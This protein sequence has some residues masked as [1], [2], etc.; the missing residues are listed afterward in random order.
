MKKFLSL[1]L[2]VVLSFGLFACGSSKSDDNTHKATLD[3]EQELVNICCNYS[4][5]STLSAFDVGSQNK[6]PIENGYKVTASGSYYPQDKYG[7]LGDKMLFDI[8][9]E[10]TL[11]ESGTYYR[12]NVISKNIREKTY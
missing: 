4:N 3:I 11:N 10:A 2:V 9:F 5:T 12:I 8:T 7:D 1:L 6:V